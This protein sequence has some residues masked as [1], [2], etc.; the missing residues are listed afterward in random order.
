MFKFDKYIQFLNTEGLL[1]QA[2]AVVA[3]TLISNI[4]QQ[5]VIKVIDPIMNDEKPTLNIKKFTLE[6]FNFLVV[7]Y[8]LFIITDYIKGFKF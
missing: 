8:I 4:I 6:I 1:P 5:L 3:G 7:T 2:F